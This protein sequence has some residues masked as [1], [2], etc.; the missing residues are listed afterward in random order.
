VRCGG[1]VVSVDRDLVAKIVGDESDDLVS[2]RILIRRFM[3][4][5]RRDFLARVRWASG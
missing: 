3:T 1:E 4:V 2:A 5:L